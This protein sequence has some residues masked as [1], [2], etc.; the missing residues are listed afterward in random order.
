M[1]NKKRAAAFT[2]V[3]NENY[4]LKKWIDHYS[5]YYNLSD[6]F[7]LDHYSKDES[8]KNLDVNVFQPDI[9]GGELAY[10]HDW[11]KSWIEKTYKDLLNDYECVMFTDV[12]EIIFTVDKPFNQVIEDFL[13]DKRCLV[14]SINTWDL[15]QAEG[16]KDLSFDDEI[17][18]NRKYMVR[19]IANNFKY[20]KTLL[21][22][23][24][25]RFD[26]G[27]HNMLN[28]KRDF[29]YELKMLHLKKY[30]FKA[31]MA[32]N[33]YRNKFETLFSDNNGMQNKNNT[34]EFQ[35]NFF[36]SENNSQEFYREIPDKWR[37]IL[38]G[39]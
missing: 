39:L 15:I 8:T 19:H 3:K 36:N 27:H 2:I 37:T 34:I 24:I 1:S 6:L 14:Q 10:D 29:K 23:H 28:F 16:E 18:P 13:N 20:D 4:F 32:R 33:E 11:M 9:N 25:P 5:K 12:D 22:K 38:K 26:R 31:M 17:I 21:S 35:K 30:D 7:V